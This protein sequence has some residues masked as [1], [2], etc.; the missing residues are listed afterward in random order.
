[1][2]S[3]RT[4]RK[5]TAKSRISSNE[6]PSMIGRIEFQELCSLCDRPMIDGAMCLRNDQTKNAICVLCMVG[7]AEVE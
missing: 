5:S 2:M 7:I 1:M 3:E 6:P 4:F